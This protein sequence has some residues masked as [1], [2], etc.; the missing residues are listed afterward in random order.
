MRNN[1][2]DL[3]PIDRRLLEA[4]QQ[5]ARASLVDL[6]RLVDLSPSGLQKRLRKL[7]EQGAVRCYAA[8][9]DRE[10]MGYD[11]LC[12]VSVTLNRHEP[13]G[14]DGF[15]RAVQTIPEVLEC[16]HITGE[17]DY[18]LKVVVRNRSHLERFLIEQ[19][20]PLPGIDKIRTSI[21]LR[22]IKATTALPL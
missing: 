7:E 8:V 12:F 18:L 10:Q 11:L 16:H 2:A 19:L 9:L 3:D 17:H 22:E 5:D 20:T 15:R 14:V 13:A 4:L 6:A 1:H 21:V